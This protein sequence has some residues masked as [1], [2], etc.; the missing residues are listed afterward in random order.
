[1]RS[2]CQL[3]VTK[4]HMVQTF[5]LKCPPSTVHSAQAEGTMQKD[6]QSTAKTRS[7][8]FL[9]HNIGKAELLHGA[10][11]YAIVHVEVA[12]PGTFLVLSLA[13]PRHFESFAAELTRKV[14]QLP[15]HPKVEW[16]RAL[17]RRLQRLFGWGDVISTREL[18]AQAC[19]REDDEELMKIL[20]EAAALIRRGELSL[21]PAL[22]NALSSP[23][24]AL[25]DCQHEFFQE[26]PY[27]KIFGPCAR[28]A[29]GGKADARTHTCPYTRCAQCRI[30]LCSRC[31]ANDEA[32]QEDHREL[33]VALQEC[34]RPLS[35]PFGP[36]S[37]VVQHEE[38]PRP[39]FVTDQTKVPNEEKLRW[40]EQENGTGADL[41]TFSAKFCELFGEKLHGHTP[42]KRACLDLFASYSGTATAKKESDLPPADVE[43]FQK[44]WDPEAPRRC[45]ECNKALPVTARTLFCNLAC[46][47]ASKKIT[48]GRVVE[49]TVVPKSS[50]ETQ[51]HSSRGVDACIYEPPQEEIVRYCDGKVELVGGCRVCAKCGQGREVEKLCV[52]H[53]VCVAETVLDKSLKRSAESMIYHSNLLNFGTGADPDHVPAWTKRRRL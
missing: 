12:E 53:L 27:Q 31:A 34:K 20:P 36:T 1:M 30:V 41:A 6:G 51:S 19:D 17:T 13:T 39:F 25:T 47:N 40:I 33:Q 21:L 28:G 37:Q 38:A 5:V 43:E 16:V 14:E 29:P 4:P 2:L 50:R 35:T 7:V 24:P 45:R 18:V 26:A 49:R 44:V 52:G 42:Q 32:E 22:H 48:C 15:G 10:G 46:E 8:P 9:L 3:G 11:A 23:L